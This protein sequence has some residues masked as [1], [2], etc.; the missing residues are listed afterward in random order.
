MA[1]VF[2]LFF[3]FFKSFSCRAADMGNLINFWG[4]D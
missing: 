3:Y 2:I 1:G 4:L